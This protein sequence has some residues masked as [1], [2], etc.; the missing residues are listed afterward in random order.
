MIML[1]FSPEFD[2]K[3]DALK[4]YIDIHY[5][6]KVRRKVVR[7]INE[8]IRM[9]KKY[10]EAGICLSEISEVQTDYRY[11]FV[12]HNYIFYTYDGEKV[13][14]VKMYGEEEDYML[15]VFGISGRTQESIDYWGE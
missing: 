9:L 1:V 10:P 12:A 3:Y 13:E 8:R 6:E 15:Q 5:G 11:F 14:I 4:K 7:T 2:E